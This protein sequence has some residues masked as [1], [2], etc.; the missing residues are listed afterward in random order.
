MFTL[1][2]YEN[3]NDRSLK[4]ELI[5]LLVSFYASQDRSSDNFKIFDE[6][7]RRVIPLPQNIHAFLFLDEPKRSKL[8]LKEIL[9]GI[10]NI[11]GKWMRRWT[12]REKEMHFQKLNEV[13]SFLETSLEIKN[14]DGK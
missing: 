12:G 11:P 6:L 8:S 13:L 4:R 1:T 5:R 14:E 10:R 7:S 9:F 2:N 3:Q